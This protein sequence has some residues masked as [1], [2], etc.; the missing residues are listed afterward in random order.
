MSELK[1]MVWVRWIFIRQGCA[2]GGQGAAV[3]GGHSRLEHFPKKKVTVRIAVRGITSE[4]RGPRTI[5]ILKRFVT[6]CVLLKMKYPLL[7]LFV[8]CYLLIASIPK[9]PPKTR[10][11][12]YGGEGRGK[13]TDS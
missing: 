7:Y 10:V 2:A 3:L 4:W 8:V 13:R 9:N 5:Q 11:L 1:V 6:L 12:K